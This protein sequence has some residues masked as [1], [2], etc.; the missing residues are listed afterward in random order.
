MLN[1]DTEPSARPMTKD[2]DKRDQ[3]V[4]AEKSAH[5]SHVLRIDRNLA[6]RLRISARSLFFLLQQL[7]AQ[8]GQPFQLFVLLGDAVGVAL[9]VLGA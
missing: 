5:E 4:D 1:G 8:L 2:D 7:V 9:L 6:A 3:H